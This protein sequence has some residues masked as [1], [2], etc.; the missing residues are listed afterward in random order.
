MSSS[1]SS[2]EFPTTFVLV[3]FRSWVLFVH[4]M[5][6]SNMLNVNSKQTKHSEA[7]NTPQISLETFV[8]TP[9]S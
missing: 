7:S 3:L 6:R 8:T 1:I 9:N 4:V 5:H 2:C